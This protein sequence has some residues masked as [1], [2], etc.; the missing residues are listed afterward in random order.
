LAGTA[1]GP[2]GEVVWYTCEAKGVGPDTDA[3]EEVALVVLDEIS[4]ADVS[5]A[6]GIDYS[7]RN[8]T[9]G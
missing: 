3:C 9:V 2:D 4:S 5:D 6:S 1:S 8:V 7:L